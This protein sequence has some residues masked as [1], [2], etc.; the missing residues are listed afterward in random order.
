MCM[1]VEEITQENIVIQELDDYI[2]ANGDKKDTLV[3]RV[4]K[5]N[6]ITGIQIQQDLEPLAEHVK[7]CIESP[8][9]ARQLKNRMLVTAG[10][11]VLVGFVMF[12]AFYTF[13][14]V[15]GYAEALAILK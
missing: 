7:L 2:A 8:S 9:L 5:Q 10:K 12:M 13:V 11:I 15:V 3:M 14:E 6:M 1:T 4:L